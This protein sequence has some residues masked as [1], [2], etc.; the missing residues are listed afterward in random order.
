MEVIYREITFAELN[1]EIFSEFIRKQIVT[2]CWRKVNGDWIIKSDPFI[3]DWNNNDLAF[4]TECLK[5]T[6][7]TGGLLYGAFVKEKLKGFV[8]VESAA[9][10]SDK[11]YLDLS[12]IHVS[13][14]MRRQGIGRKL[15]E[16]AKQYAKQKNAKKLYISAHSAVETQAF[17]KAMKCTEAQEYDK[18][19]VEKEP[20]DC[21]LE[22]VL[23]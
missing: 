6:V 2:D 1:T 11:Q 14:D 5:N 10:G 18:H 21:Q 23:E 20:Y 17:Y 9:L 8:S 4:L 22:Y 7:S 15:F 12:C 16:T 13:K 3:D 19:H